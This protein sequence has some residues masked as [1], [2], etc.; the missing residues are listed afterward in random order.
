MAVAG[1]V[2]VVI[3]VAS[4]VEPP[5]VVAGIGFVVVIVAM[6]LVVLQEW[7]KQR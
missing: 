3:G 2:L 4:I 7:R 5:G 6:I 1:V